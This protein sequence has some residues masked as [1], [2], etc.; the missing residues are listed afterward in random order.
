[1]L[2]ALDLNGE[3][4]GRGHEHAVIAPAAGMI[5]IHGAAQRLGPETRG[6][7]DILGFAIDQQAIDARTVHR[8]IS[9]IVVG[10]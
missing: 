7:I 3:L 2:H 1:M 8:S 5:R 4:A 6:R 10:E 9:P